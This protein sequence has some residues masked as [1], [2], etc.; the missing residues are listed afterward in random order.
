VLVSSKDESQGDESALLPGIPLLDVDDRIH[1]ALLEELC[2]DYGVTDSSDI[3]L[4][5]F[6]I[7]P[8]DVRPANQC[9]SNVRWQ[10]DRKVMAEVMTQGE[11]RHI[12]HGHTTQRIYDKID[13]SKAVASPTISSSC[14][15]SQTCTSVDKCSTEITSVSVHSS[16]SCQSAVTKVNETLD[17]LVGNSTVLCNARKVEAVQ[18]SKDGTISV[19]KREL[20]CTESKSNK[21]CYTTDEDYSGVSSPGG[22]HVAKKLKITNGG[23]LLEDVRKS[24]EFVRGAAIFSPAA[25]QNLVTTQSFWPQPAINN[26]QTIVTPKCAL[27]SVGNPLKTTESSG[28][29]NCHMQ[30]TKKMRPHCQGGVDNRCGSADFGSSHSYVELPVTDDYSGS[31]TGSFAQNGQGF[32]TG[33]TDAG[34][35]NYRSA[36]VYTNMSNKEQLIRG[37]TVSKLNSQYSPAHYDS[38]YCNGVSDDAKSSFN[39]CRSSVGPSKMVH[40]HNEHSHLTP[41]NRT[42]SFSFQAQYLGGNHDKSEQHDSALGQNQQQKYPNVLSNY[43]CNG[44]QNEFLQRRYL[45]VPFSGACSSNQSIASAHNS[46]RFGMTGESSIPG[47]FHSVAWRPGSA[48]LY[49]AHTNASHFAYSNSDAIFPNDQTVPCMQPTNGYNSGMDDRFNFISTSDMTSDGLQFA[50]A[51]ECRQRSQ[52]LHPYISVD[53]HST[54]GILPSDNSIPNNALVL[55][56][57]QDQSSRL[58]SVHKRASTDQSCRGFV[59]HLV[60]EGSGPYRLHPLFPLL[61]DLVIADMNFEAPSFPYPLLAGIPKSFDRLVENYFSSN[62]RATTRLGVDPSI[63]NIIMDALRYAHSSL[64]GKF[65]C[66]YY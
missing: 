51:A 47:S 17:K 22:V 6:D 61:R 16:S 53:V 31:W 11:Q 18:H 66:D 13:L 8:A 58:S 32:D 12:L 54:V 64:I 33:H 39:V 55:P 19:L 62:R 14:E 38:S 48:D 59:Q 28:S 26:R 23:D 56:W 25:S 60:G 9:H 5:T 29:S 34:Y 40:R 49:S 7:P 42:E 37:Q 3:D 2:A 4:L 36:D 65:L 24:Y 57:A 50:P 52:R 27:P 46:T 45:N 43:S 41:D 20:D 44:N 1:N 10:D 35:Q 15:E 63:D 30:F 21:S